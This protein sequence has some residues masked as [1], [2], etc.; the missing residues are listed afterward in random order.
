MK[1][2]KIIQLNK[3]QQIIFDIIKKSK[4]PK[5]AYS[6]LSDVQKK[7]LKAPLQ[8]YR[9]LNKLISLGLVHKIESQ[10]AY[11]NCSHMNCN[12]SGI[13]FSICKNCNHITEVKNDTVHRYL[14]VL[15]SP[16]GQ[17]CKSYKL[18]LYGTCKSCA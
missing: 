17:K 9:A 5:K 15:K 10:N 2:T 3:N 7:G 16:N 14:S 11:M 18:E 4:Q 1:L 6:I 12:G 13:I 8:V